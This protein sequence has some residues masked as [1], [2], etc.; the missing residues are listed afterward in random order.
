MVLVLASW[1]CCCHEVNYKRTVMLSWLRCFRYFVCIE[2]SKISNKGKYQYNN[3]LGR[4][5]MAILK[6]ENLQG[7]V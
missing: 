7:F 5:F 1:D 4:D 3:L 2:T 6:L